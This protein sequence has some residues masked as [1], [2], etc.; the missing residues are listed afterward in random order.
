M[1][2]LPVAILAHLTAGGSLVT[3]SRQRAAAL[4][5]AHSA[6]ML[7]R[8]LT[9]WSSPDILP[10][11]AWVERELEQARSRGE[12][13]PRRLSSAEQWQLWREVVLQCSEPLQMLAPER[14]VDPVRR[15]SAVL[16]DEGLTLDRTSSPEAALLLEAQ[17][18]YR[19]RCR[20]LGA[21]GSD[22]WVQCRAYLRPSAQLML[23]GFT[24][25]GAE[26]RRWLE[27]HGA[28]VLEA[29][30]SGWPACQPHVSA[31]ASP[32]TESQAAADWC[33][34]QLSQDP[35]ARLLLIVPRLGQQ[36]HHWL[37]ALSQ[38][39]DP[40]G[41]LGTD[42]GER[43][44][45]VIEGGRALAEHPLVSTALDVIALASGRADLEQLS[46]L[47]RSP[48]LTGWDLPSRLR[49]DL[50]LREQGL[51]PPTLAGLIPQSELIGAQA[52]IQSAALAQA[53]YEALQVPPQSTVGS[54]AEC[55]AEWLARCGWPGEDLGSEE[56]QVRLRFDALLGEL[57]ALDPAARRL[58]LD[59]AVDLLQ[60]RAQREHFEPA[61]DDVAVT[62]TASLEDPI[63]RYDGIWVAGLSVDAW[64]GPAQTDPLIPASLQRQAG[65]PGSTP[66]LQLAQA[67]RLQGVWSRCAR[68]CVL[69]WA[70][71]EEDAPAEASALLQGLPAV[72]PAAHFELA[73]WLASRPVTLQSWMEPRGALW[74]PGRALRGGAR[75]LELQSLCPFR[76]YAQLRLGACELDAAERGVAPRERGRILHRALQLFW[77]AVRVSQGLH[78]DTATTRLEE[79]AARCARQAIQEHAP[80][81]GGLLSSLLLEHECERTRVLLLRLV[82]WERAREP[83]AAAALESPA[84]LV[85][86]GHHLPLRLDRVDRLQD[87]RLLVIDYKSGKPQ[88]FDAHGERPEQPQLAAYALALGHDVA[89]VAMVYFGGSK[90]SVRGAADRDGRLPKLGGLPAGLD[91][92]A[93]QTQ[94][95]ERLG[96]LAQEFVDGHAA[97]D[98]QPRACERCHLQMLCRIDVLQLDAVGAEDETQREGASAFEEPGGEDFIDE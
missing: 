51:D 59:Q 22:S 45:Y 20:E 41:V 21:L 12:P 88:P 81:A 72:T 32:A 65:L 28:V 5:L 16:E 77:E 68:A 58:S 35:S 46:A 15:A 30:D 23:A 61:S 82:D 2:E 44:P 7:A 76:A 89:A 86:A 75:L 47:L 11:G 54:W 64:P 4:R 74:A 3:P 14:L 92:S 78:G 94:W 49:L 33:V 19:H 17:A 52:G 39:L 34:E 83:F 85:L 42:S 90:I 26:R 96:A 79:Q 40:R 55:F 91:W 95:R 71:G 69:S 70:A 18:A 8:G 56:Q 25:L 53:L 6:L 63:A 10:W 9:L 98:P 24:H 84:Q 13:L 87:G 36:R 38:R 48:Y 50:W 66:A 43:A 57:A 80:R 67:R 29:D 97:V 62:V 73:D 1:L 93:L 60:E 37:R 31:H 27:Q